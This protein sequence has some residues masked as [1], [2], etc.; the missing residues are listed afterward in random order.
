[1][2]ILFLQALYLSDSVVDKNKVEPFMMT[3]DD[4]F[5]FGP[6]LSMIYL[7]MSSDLMHLFSVSCTMFKAVMFRDPV[8]GATPI[9][10]LSYCLHEQRD[11]KTHTRNV[12]MMAE[13]VKEWSSF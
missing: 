9:I 6:F 12:R 3:Y 2:M 13:C 5:D 1:M 10:P 8:T 4:T 7:I 11:T